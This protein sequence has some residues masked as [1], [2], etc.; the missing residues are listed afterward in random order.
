MDTSDKIASVLFCYAILSTEYVRALQVPHLDHSSVSRYRQGKERVPHILDRSVLV[1]EPDRSVARQVRNCLSS[2]GFAILGPV[3]SVQDGLDLFETHPVDAV[4]T[5]LTFAAGDVPIDQLSAAAATRGIPVI[6]VSSR[7]DLSA[8][9]Q[10]VNGNAA[11]YILKPFAD[12]QLVSAVLVAVLTVERTSTAAAGPRVLTSDEKLRA[13][14]ALLNDQPLP[15]SCPAG[16]G[17]DGEPL[18][19][20]SVRER[21]IVELLANGARVVTIAQHLTLSP[22]TVRNHLKSVFRKL[23]LRGQHELFEYWRARA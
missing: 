4:V 15:E 1:I 21:E 8:L 7:A 20:L 2:A 5:D 19:T 13:I 16:D 18:D 9:Q 10:A 23:N 12:R 14:A 11:A 6:Y 3:S 22:H 17:A